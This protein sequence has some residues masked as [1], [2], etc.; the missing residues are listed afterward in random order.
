MYFS[1]CNITDHVYI[2]QL[3]KVTLPLTNI[4]GI[5]NQITI[6]IAHQVTSVRVPGSHD[7]LM[8]I[9]VFW[10]VTPYLPTYNTLIFS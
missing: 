2:Q 10:D 4:V 1:L 3:T 7:L 8:K 6:L 5:C 9:H